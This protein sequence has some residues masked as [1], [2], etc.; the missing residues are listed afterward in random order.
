MP[1]TNSS[2]IVV[3]TAGI[4]GSSRYAATARRIT[5]G[6]EFQWI[7]EDPAKALE[8]LTYLRA[9]VALSAPKLRIHFRAAIS[10]RWP[11]TSRPPS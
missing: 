1:T 7:V 2:R 3:V 5:A 8:T 10:G 4:V 6:D 11:G 9:V